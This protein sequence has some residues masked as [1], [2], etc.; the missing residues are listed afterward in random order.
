MEEPPETGDIVVRRVTQC[1]VFIGLLS[2]SEKRELTKIY[3][4]F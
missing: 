1:L 4:L 3:I 2:A